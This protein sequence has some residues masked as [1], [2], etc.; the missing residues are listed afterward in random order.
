VLG[1]NPTRKLICV[2]YSQD[3]ARKHALDTRK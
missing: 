1:Q 2:S 3:L